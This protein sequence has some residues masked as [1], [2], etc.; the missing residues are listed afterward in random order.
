MMAK[1][2]EDGDDD[3]D[4]HNHNTDDEND[5]TG[6]NIGVMITSSIIKR[7]TKVIKI[8]STIAMIWKIQ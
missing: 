2:I 5:H 4:N 6:N 8:T 1:L 3:D 7:E